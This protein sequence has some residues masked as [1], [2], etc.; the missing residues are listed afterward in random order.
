MLLLAILLPAFHEDYVWP[1][2]LLLSL[3]T[4]AWRPGYHHKHGNRS[5]RAAWELGRGLGAG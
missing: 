5:G 2:L 3:N 1:L 4:S